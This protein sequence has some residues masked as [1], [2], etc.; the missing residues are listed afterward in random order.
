M[1]QPIP[2]N[3]VRES[4]FLNSGFWGIDTVLA[5]SVNGRHFLFP[6]SPVTTQYADLLVV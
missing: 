6:P 1:P 2:D 3:D 5:N 4:A